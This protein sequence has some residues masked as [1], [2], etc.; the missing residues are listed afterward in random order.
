MGK[1]LS[2]RQ[3][4][5]LDYIK[6]QIELK[7]YA[8]SIRDICNGVGLKS[9]STV[10]SHLNTLERKGYLKKDPTKPRA[11]TIL[12][13]TCC[14]DLNIN[15]YAKN[16]VDL[17]SMPSVKGDDLNGFFNPLL[18]D[19]PHIAI[20]KNRGDSMKDIGLFDDDYALVDTSKHE[21]DNQIVLA[22]VNNE[23]STIKRFIRDGDMVKLACENDSCDFIF[24]NS[25]NVKV[26][27]VVTGFFRNFS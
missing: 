17:P 10:H 27:G 6:K 15:H 2:I 21:I 7:G 8:P 18:L 26:I 5:V 3:L 11:I 9:T 22:V 19:N 20:Y 23:Y 4:Q 25:K 13:S 24:V 1:D 14:D 12:D 16:G